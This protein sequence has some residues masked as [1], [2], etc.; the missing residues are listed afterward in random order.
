MTFTQAALLGA[1][2]GLTEFFPVSSSG[3]LAIVQYYLKDFSQPGILFDILLHWGTLVSLL[4]FFRGE[5]LSI[6]RAL[7]P[8]SAKSANPGASHRRLLLLIIIATVPTGLIG[9]SLRG[10]VVEAFSSLLVVSIFLLVTGLLVILAE[11][12]RKK[13][14][15]EELSF[16]DALLIG[17]SQGLA[18]FP[19]LSRSGVTIASG[20]FRGLEGTLAARF[21]FLLAIPV[22][23]G[24]GLL[25]LKEATGIPPSDVG[26]YLVGMAVAGITGYYAIKAMM[27]VVRNRNFAFFGIYCLAA[28]GLFL[29]AS[30]S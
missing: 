11:V 28:G 23:A 16:G 2:Q 26:P 21:S 30:L 13:K 29:Y 27:F 1:V 8:G 6:F 4:I 9:Y 19:G 18:V 14:G 7:S 22:I 5:L 12:M 24:A 10:F 15:K 3:H 25:E 20:L 17:I